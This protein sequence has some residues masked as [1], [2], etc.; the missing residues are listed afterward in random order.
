MLS[1]KEPEKELEK[2]EAKLK[3][4]RFKWADS[5]PARKRMIEVVAKMHTE[6]RDMLIKIIER[7]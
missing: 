1:E 2:V 6:K 5:S 3:E 7:Y 4:L